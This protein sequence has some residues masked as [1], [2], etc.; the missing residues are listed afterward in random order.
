[1]SENKMRKRNIFVDMDGVLTDFNTHYHT[2]LDVTTSDA[3]KQGFEYYVQLWDKFLDQQGFAQLPWFD[4]GMQLVH[5]LEGLD[6]SKYQLCIMTSAGGYHRQAEVYQQKAKWLAN[7]GI[8][9]PIVCVPGK[10]YKAGFADSRSL[11]IDDT[12]VNVENFIRAG[13]EAIYHTGNIDIV[14]E[15]LREWLSH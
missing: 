8:D 2:L 3:R 13:G 1:M 9:W 6:E 12:K 4:G 15:E 7:N 5:E 11:L 10:S 14:L